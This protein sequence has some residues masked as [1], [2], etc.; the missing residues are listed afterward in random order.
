MNVSIHILHSHTIAGVMPLPIRRISCIRII[1][2]PLLP[3]GMGISISIAREVLL[4]FNG[5]GF[6]VGSRP[7]AT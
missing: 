6:A 3:S 2:R 1:Y 5:I 4:D 7:V